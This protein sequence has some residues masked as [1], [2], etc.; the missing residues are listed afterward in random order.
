MKPDPV[1]AALARLAAAMPGTPEGRKIFAAA[2]AAKQLRLVVKAAR[3]VEGFQAAEFCPQMSQALA[4]LMARG[5]GADKGCAAML[6]LARA[7]VN[8]DYDEA[9]L[10]LDGMKFV[11]KEASW[12]PAVDVAADLRASCAMG[13]VNSRYA[14][15]LQAL[16]DLLVD[17]EWGG[18]VG[19]IRALAAIGSEP[20]MLLLYFK[21]KVG[22][23]HPEVISQCLEALLTGGGEGAL[24]LATSIALGRDEEA[25]EA[26]I[27][28]LG[29]S[30][31]ADAI[32]WLITR[33]RLPGLT[34]GCLFLAL[35]SSRTETALEFLLGLVTTS[36]S[37]TF[38]EVH[39]ALTIHRRDAVLSEQIDAAITRRNQG[40][41]PDRR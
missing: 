12:G 31:R 24:E 25:G 8:L 10:Y 1:D 22:D 28:A 19:A 32:T 7:L 41:V 21:A 5:D 35:S 30:R 34:R 29:A 20:A 2:L 39:E 38:A 6:A 9:E 26:A 14:G 23:A 36:D 40:K 15:K 33:S 17:K 27:L 3:L 13:L 18:R 4:A 16:T 11:Q 37:A